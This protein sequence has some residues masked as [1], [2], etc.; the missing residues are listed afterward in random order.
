LAS[1]G[2]K[3]VLTDIE[4]STVA[5]LA[6]EIDPTGQHALGLALDVGSEEA[7][8]RAVQ[9]TVEAFGGLN[10]LVN[11]AGISSPPGLEDWDAEKWAQV[12]RIN[13]TGV[14][15]GMNSVLPSLK[16]G[17]GSIVNISSIWAHTGGE[18]RSIGYVA[19]KASVLGMTK[20]AAL[21]LAPYGIRVNSV[22]P[23]YIDHLMVGSRGNPPADG[24]PLGRLANAGEISG[25][26]AFLLSSDASYV[27][28]VDILVDGGMHLG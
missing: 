4:D 13:Q 10:G 23:G 19:S 24:I 20:A 22:S 15:L 7:W 16:A 21:E 12:T 28:G 17:G 14:L 26:V 3:V 5:R 11:N 8:T 2:A 6:S 27:T 1:E 25:A 18:G 9:R